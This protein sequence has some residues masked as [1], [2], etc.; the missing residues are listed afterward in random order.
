MKKPRCL[1]SQLASD[2]SGK[3]GTKQ[4]PHFACQK[5]ASFQ[6]NLRKTNKFGSKA[7][8]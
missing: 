6:F 3:H 8:T 2:R 1:T 4:K 5:N 7:A